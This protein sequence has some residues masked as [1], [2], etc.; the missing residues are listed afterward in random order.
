MQVLRNCLLFYGQCRG[1]Y[2][3]VANIPLVRLY[4]LRFLS[5][6][7]VVYLIVVDHRTVGY[8]TSVLVIFGHRKHSV[9]L[10]NIPFS[11]CLVFQRETRFFYLVFLPC[12]SISNLISLTLRT[13]YLHS[14]CLRYVI[15]LC[16]TR[17]LFFRPVIRFFS[18]SRL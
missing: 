14:L 5:F 16:L 3:P 10:H 2:L 8:C 1:H 11:R 12:L 7:A 13:L 9:F 18:V 4:A 17:G 15:C 6:C